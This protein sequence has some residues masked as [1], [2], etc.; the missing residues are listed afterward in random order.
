[1]LL[2]RSLADFYVTNITDAGLPFT[3][4]IEMTTLVDRSAFGGNALVYL[5]RYLTQS[6][7]AWQHSDE[8]LKEEFLRG[9]ERMYPEFR[10]EHVLACTIA[11]VREVLAVTTLNYTESCLPPLVT[12]APRIL[13]ANSAQIA[14]GTLNV[15]ETIALGTARA[16]EI[17]AHLAEL[18]ATA[19]WSAR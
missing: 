9:V 3:G 8:A 18:P 5:P 13:I 17:G 2:E 14:Q 19:A 10:R 12:S 16:A 1:M 7:P 4:V 15:N 6:D 11:R